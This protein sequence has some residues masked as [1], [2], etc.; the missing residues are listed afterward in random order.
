VEPSPLRLGN[1]KGHIILSNEK[2]QK[3]VTVPALASSYHIVV[4]THIRWL[5]LYCECF[6]LICHI[7]SAIVK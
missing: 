2:D 4:Y 1:T 3:Q 7:V 5:L 6:M